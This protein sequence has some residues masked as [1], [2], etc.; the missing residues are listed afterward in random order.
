MANHGTYHFELIEAYPACAIVF[1]ISGT[2]LGPALL[3][4]AGRSSL[5]GL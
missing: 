4:M 1:A 2:K 3:R 5:V